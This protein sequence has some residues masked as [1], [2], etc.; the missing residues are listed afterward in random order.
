MILEVTA[1]TTGFTAESGNDVI[2]AHEGDDYLDGGSGNDKLYGYDGDD[3]MKGGTGND[4]I[5]GNGRK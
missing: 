5:D 2:Y 3:V 4:Y 1:V